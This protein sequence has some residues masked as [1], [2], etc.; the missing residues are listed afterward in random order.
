MSRHHD[1]T[2]QVERPDAIEQRDVDFRGVLISMGSLLALLVLALIFV[3]WLFG[4]FSVFQQEATSPLPKAGQMPPEP[5][6]QVHPLREMWEL[7]KRE[8]SIL[9]SYGWVQHET[10]VARIP[11]DRAMDLLAERGLPART[12]ADVGP[13]VAG[14]GPESGGPQTGAPMERYNRPPNG[15][16][17]NPPPAAPVPGPPVPR[18]AVPSGIVPEANR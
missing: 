9:N 15:A 17:S 16:V 13:T 18:T 2:A 12:G 11:I 3:W 6:V 10:G 1:G 5:R 7:R 8:A 4:A 14:T